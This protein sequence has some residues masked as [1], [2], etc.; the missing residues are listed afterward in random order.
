L[1][2]LVVEEIVP[3]LGDIVRLGTTLLVV[4]QSVQVALR[5]ADNV[6]YMDR[7]GIRALGPPNPESAA[8][9][10]ALMMGARA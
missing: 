2:P 3:V 5:I 1:A 8:S 9:I 10:A 7:V 4:E 6:L